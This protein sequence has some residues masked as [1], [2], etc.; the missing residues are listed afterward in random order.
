MIIDVYKHYIFD[1]LDLLSQIRL[2]ATCWEFRN[3]L[4]ITDM[5]NIDDKYKEQ[6]TQTIIDKYKNL[7]KLDASNNPKITNV[8]NLA[9]LEILGA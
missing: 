7:K 1:Y 2:F 3:G 9:K 6:L 4:D 5:Y 8:N